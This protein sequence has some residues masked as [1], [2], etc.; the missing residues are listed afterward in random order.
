MEKRRIEEVR[1]SAAMVKKV[2][3]EESVE[4]VQSNDKSGM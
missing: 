2:Q 1:G 3:F 4:I